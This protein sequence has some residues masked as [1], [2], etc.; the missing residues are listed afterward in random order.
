MRI[1]GEKK[2]I[3]SSLDMDDFVNFSN[4]SSTSDDLQKGCRGKQSAFVV[5]KVREQIFSWGGEK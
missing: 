1:R 3:T 4:F 2:K 5:D